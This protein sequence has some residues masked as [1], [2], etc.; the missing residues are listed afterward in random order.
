[1]G[2]VSLM[3]RLKES[4]MHGRRRGEGRGGGEGGGEGGT[5]GMHDELI[6][7]GHMVKES[8]DLKARTAL[9]AVESTL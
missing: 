3:R 2:E 8:P 6:C 5:W 1:M 9:E 7:Q 4:A